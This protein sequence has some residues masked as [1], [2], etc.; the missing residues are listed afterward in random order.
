MYLEQQLDE[1]EREMAQLL[2]ASHEQRA[3]TVEG[4]EGLLASERA[5][6]A[7][8]SRRSET[9]SLQLQMT[10]GELLLEVHHEARELIQREGFNHQAMRWILTSTT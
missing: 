8:A 3:K 10:R 1:R 6:K 4:F 5:A 9:L 2:R 7:E